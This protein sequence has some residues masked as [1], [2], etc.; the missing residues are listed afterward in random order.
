MSIALWCVL[1]AGMMPV[2]TV[3][4]AKWGMRYDN[5]NPREQAIALEGYRKRA[6]A[7]HLN[8]YE[9]FAFFAVAV[10]IAEW[11]GALP[12]MVNGLAL[13]FILMRL[14][15]VLFYLTDKAS[16]RSIVWALGWF[17]TIALFTSPIWTHA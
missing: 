13:F 12:A 7:A 4:V 10:L 16:L 1:L 15:Y 11:K 17:T 9:A 3:A 5:Y 2:L 14:C 8:A 6:Y